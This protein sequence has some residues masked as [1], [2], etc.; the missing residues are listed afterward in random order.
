[1]ATGK[2]SRRPAG[3]DHIMMG[4]MDWTTP[5]E[6]SE[7]HRRRASRH[8]AELGAPLIR[9]S[10]R[11]QGHPQLPSM[12]EDTID[13]SWATRILEEA[14]DAVGSPRPEMR[15]LRDHNLREQ[16]NTLRSLPEEIEPQVPPPLPARRE[17]EMRPNSG[18]VLGGPRPIP[19][20]EPIRSLG[21]PLAHHT[22]A[23]NSRPFFA[24]PSTQSSRQPQPATHTVRALPSAPHVNFTLGR[25]TP[26]R[27]DIL[28]A[29]Q[30]RGRSNVSG[31]RDS[32]LVVLSDSD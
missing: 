16:S 24:F 10:D 25:P 13:E 2:T 8:Y 19:V 1:M 32:P 20:P 11:Q 6:R 30:A 31:S 9:P 14:V 15:R 5:A 12:G 29:R 28:A 26:L 18:S 21:G 7:A 4:L 27:S 23:T 17:R 22:N 3:L